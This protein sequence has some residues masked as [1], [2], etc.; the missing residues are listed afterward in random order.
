MKTTRRGRVVLGLLI[1]LAGAL[2]GCEFGV[3]VLNPDFL[4]QIGVD[5]SSIARPQGNIIVAFNNTTGSRATMLAFIADNPADLSEGA[6]NFSAVV[7]AGGIRNE[8]LDCPIGLIC[9]GSVDGSYEVSGIAAQVEVVED[10]TQEVV[11]VE[12]N[13]NFALES[14]VGFQCGDVIEI[15]LEDAVLDGQQAFQVRINVIPG[16]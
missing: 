12:Y 11:Q 7:D 4:Q 5:A 10:E 3:D 15:R 9:A 6:R 2:A 14:G 1:V 16:Q 13:V 8:V